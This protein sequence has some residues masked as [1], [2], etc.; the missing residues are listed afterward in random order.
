MD[1]KD[2]AVLFLRLATIGLLSMAV[3]L[4]FAI[5]KIF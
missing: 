4:G 5:G 2:F 3:L 1:W